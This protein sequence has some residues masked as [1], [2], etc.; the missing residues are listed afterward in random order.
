MAD[1]QDADGGWTDGKYTFPLSKPI[2][3]ED[4]E[5]KTLTIREPTASDIIACGNPVEFNPISDPP[6]VR[7]RDREMGA[8][9][10][11]LTN[12][13]PVGI[14]RMAPKDLI[15]AGWVLAPFFVPV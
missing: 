6:S 5:L 11:R 8:M 7:I 3:T 1:E 13:S 10:S 4:G 14:G 12:I 15:N 2:L 9:L